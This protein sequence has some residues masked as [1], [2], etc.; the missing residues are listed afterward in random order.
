MSEIWKR[1]RGWP[2]YAVSDLGRIKRLAHRD[3]IGR[4]WPER[5]KKARH[6]GYIVLTAGKRHIRTRRPVAQFVLLAF[7]GPPPVGKEQACHRDDVR[8]NNK[9]SNLYWGDSFD[10]HQDRKRNDGT[11]LGVPITELRR[12][13]IS[14]GLR[15]FSK[16]QGNARTLFGETKTLAEW[17]EDPR[18]K[19]APTTLRMRLHRGWSF[20]DALTTPLSRRNK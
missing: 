20:R 13:G 19:V 1:I 14:K 3:H 15:R 8:T 7:V 11:L 9:L 5:I 12:S 16:E 10:N 17:A 4:F 18:C 6:D 2:N